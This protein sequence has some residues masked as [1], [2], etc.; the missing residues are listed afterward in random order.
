MGEDPGEGF[1]ARL[2][3]LREAA[4]LTQEQLAERAGLSAKA[5]SALE[6]GE[7]RRPYPHTLE[8]LA[9][10]LAL[11]DDERAALARAVAEPA[12]APLPPLPVPPTRLVGRE[13][14][15][16]A[17]VDRLTGAE[18][19]L[20]TLT[21]P[22]GVGKTRLALAV[23]A[24]ATAAVPDGVVLVSLAPLADPALVVPAIAAAF[25]LREAAGQDLGAA[26]RA[27]LRPRRL[28]LVLDNVEHV[29]A[30]VPA[31]AELLAACPGLTVL[32]TSR[33]PLH[34]R[35]EQEYPVEPLG[36]PDLARVPTPAEAATAA[37]VRLFVE[38]AREVAPAFELTRGNAAAVAAICRRLD[39]LPLAIE[40]AAAWAK[41]LPP[42]DLLARLDRALPLLAGRARDLPE[43]QRTMERTIGWSYDLL[44]PPDQAV[45]RRLAVFAGGF[46]LDAAEVVAG[47][48]CHGP[49]PRG[50]GG[51]GFARELR[52]LPLESVA[53]L[54][55]HGLLRRVERPA[56]ES[57]FGMLETVREFGLERLEASGEAD[58]VR[59]RHA[60][61]CVALAERVEDAF[62]SAEERT[63]LDRLE[64]EHDNLRAALAW[65]IGRRDAATAL[66]LAGAPWWFW[67]MRGFLAEGH[68]WLTQALALPDGEPSVPRAKAITAAGM[69]AWARGEV[70]RADE[71][72]E[73]SVALWRS[74]GDGPRVARS[75]HY[76]GLVAWQRGDF[77]TMAA[78]AEESLATA[79]AADDEVGTA[80]ARVTLGGALLRLHQ[81]A[82]ARVVL[83]QALERF[84]AR[85]M[86]RGTAWA[87]THLAEV[88]HVDGD[89]GRAFELHLRAL[90]VYRELEN[91]WGVGEELA[92][93]AALAAA[94]GRDEA[95]ARLFGAVERMR[96]T[97]G[98]A[99]QNRL[100]DPQR[101]AAELRGRL[102]EQAFAAA[103]DVGRS[104]SIEQAAAEA[105]AIAAELVGEA[106]PPASDP[107]RPLAD[108]SSPTGDR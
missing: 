9:R 35:G 5:V 56:G 18:S 57:R 88:A 16:A 75:L 30:A 59:E 74:I 70:D 78:R 101:I 53:M 51:G 12:R 61:W 40:L 11:P 82:R 45:F 42:V 36:L 84:L 60:A 99:P 97:T 23:A 86:K 1:G 49:G 77:R 29:L 13:R 38:R 105:D 90:G 10:A 72:L 64:A 94:S 63:W 48:S 50:R 20:V 96:E 31:V 80:I 102:G 4:G 2:R 39:G 43:R 89:R 27:F 100:S 24:A 58:A 107:L 65:A 79:E 103:W 54:V 7:R 15:V 28:L 46:T 41:V 47:P 67:A 108:R 69:V 22:G 19:R 106:N 21:G 37:A 98:I 95:A 73:R 93:L 25:G 83:E 33:A 34:L 26:L 87:L 62:L 91:A 14:E 52:P 3:R 85:G 68:G 71:L 81:S 76:F 92:E 6:R 17:L 55:D 44:D 66:L 104:L 8:A 32:A